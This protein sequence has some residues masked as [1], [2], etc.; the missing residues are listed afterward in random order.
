MGDTVTITINM[1]KRCAECRKPGASGS[2]ICIR[3][4]TKA[5]DPKRKM[6]SAEGQSVQ[7]RIAEKWL[8]AKAAK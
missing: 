6:H 7:R 2:G 3:C 4:V 1:D 5:M 8:A